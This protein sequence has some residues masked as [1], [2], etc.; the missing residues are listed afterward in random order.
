MMCVLVY[1]G[2]A[3]GQD[4]L[5]KYFNDTACKVKATAD[6]AQKRAILSE[7][8]QKMSKAL[9]LVEGSALVSES[10]RAGIDRFKATLQ[11]RQNELAGS[12]GYDRV[13][14]EQL[15]GFS[16]FVVQDMEQADRT[17]TIGVVTLLLI[18]I[19]VILIT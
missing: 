4:N 9:N 14:D 2:M 16:D 12:N 13:S 5:Q 10:D 8:L 3:V 17:I 18:I 15:N 7:G 6:P 19:I 1:A 11:E